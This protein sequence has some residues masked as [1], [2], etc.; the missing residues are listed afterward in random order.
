MI[1]SFIE[2]HNLILDDRSHSDA[3]T[4]DTSSPVY[5]WLEK[6]VLPSKHIDVIVDTF[7][8]LQEYGISEVKEMARLNLGADDLELLGIRPEISNLIA[9]ELSLLSSKSP[10]R[11]E[12]MG[13]LNFEFYSHNIQED[14]VYC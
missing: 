7:E 8:K 11:A 3:K 5:V 1:D 14:K 6:K 4:S 12:N 10:L 9:V 13:D 2:E